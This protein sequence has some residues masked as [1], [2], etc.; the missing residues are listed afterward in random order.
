MTAAMR[1]EPV[2]VGAQLA[3]A[4]GRSSGPGLA[5]DS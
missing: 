3:C 5:H 1:Q 2:F 4:N